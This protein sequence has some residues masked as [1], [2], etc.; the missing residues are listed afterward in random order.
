[1]NH[2]GLRSL[3]IM[4]NRGERIEVKKKGGVDKIKWG[5]YVFLKWY[6]LNWKTD[7]ERDGAKY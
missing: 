1:M 2:S 6:R 7:K 4:Q 3:K 5:C